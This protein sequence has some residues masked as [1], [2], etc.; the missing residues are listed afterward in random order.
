MFWKTES[1]GCAIMCNGPNEAIW[2][3][4]FCSG[5]DSETDGD[6]Y[7]AVMLLL[8]IYLYSAISI[9]TQ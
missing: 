3:K 1:R 5:Y 6:S 2:I 7:S 4:I 8:I 9:S